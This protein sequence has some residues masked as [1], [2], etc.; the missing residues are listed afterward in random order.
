M[1]KDTILTQQGYPNWTYDMSGRLRCPC[2]NICDP[3]GQAPCGCESPLLKI[4]MI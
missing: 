3:D 2:G 4:G 1:D